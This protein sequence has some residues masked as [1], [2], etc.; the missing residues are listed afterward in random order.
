MA[1]RP[2]QYDRDDVLDRAL[3]LFWDKGYEATGV[4]DLTSTCG[5]G[6][7]SLYNAFGDKRGLFLAALGRYN[8]AF[9]GQVIE[10]LRD[11]NE[12]PLASIATVLSTHRAEKPATGCLVAN[13]AAELGPHDE[14][15]A[16]ALRRQVDLIRGGFE[17]ALGRLQETDR[18][19][20]K[21]TPETGSHL[22]IA[23]IEGMAVLDRL[24]VDSDQLDS[25]VATVL[26][27]LTPDEST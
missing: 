23:V 17:S 1:G 10:R 7:Q 24:G 13:T 26:D 15:I 18:L 3:T 4:A 8:C 27:R 14:E 6:R 12:D 21:L 11:P 25:I 9:G 16:A 2:K 20:P 19:H 22:L 5:L